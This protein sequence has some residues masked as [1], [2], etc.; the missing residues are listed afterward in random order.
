MRVNIDYAI[1]I[2]NNGSSGSTLLHSLLDNHPKILSLPMLWGNEFYSVWERSK[3]ENIQQLLNIIE[4][5]FK[6]FFDKSHSDDGLNNMG[7]DQDKTICVS[8]KE[9]F[10]NIKNYFLY[11]SLSRKN[12]VLSIYY[13]FNK[14]YYTNLSKKNFICY[15]IHSQNKNIA[16]ML[17]EDFSKVQFIYTIRN[18][19]KNIGSIIKHLGNNYEKLPY[20]NIKNLAYSA[21]DQV[22]NDNIHHF[23][24]EKYFTHGTKF[25]FPD[26][27]NVKNLYVK[28]EDL[29]T[30]KKYI[31]KLCKKIDLEWNSSLLTST[32]MGLKWHNRK[33]SLRV[34][35]FS[36][37]IID[38]NYPEQLSEFDILRISQITNKFCKKFKYPLSKNKMNIFFYFFC[39]WKKFKCEN[40]YISNELEN[41]YF[42]TINNNNMIEKVKIFFSLK[43]QKSIIFKNIII[44]VLENI[45]VS[46]LI[47][48][49]KILK[50]YNKFKQFILFRFFLIKSHYSNVLTK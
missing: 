39:V 49:L 34:S 13:S 9:F 33:E 21:V 37:K 36:Q 29:H 17:L 20:L 44:K 50:K 31:K 23:S 28:L 35:G 38:Q 30:G 19:I 46:Y 1:A 3:P 42:S 24:Y 45:K 14:I 7:K 4:I 11:N 6:Y 10:K 48:F 2:Q 18:P 25:F 8:K 16:K 12:F 43:F 15:P 40:N 27:K 5:N 47:K 41:K 22:L 32:F 26:D